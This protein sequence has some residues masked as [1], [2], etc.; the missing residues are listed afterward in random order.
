[1]KSSVALQWYES[2]WKRWGAYGGGFLVSFVIAAGWHQWPR[3][4]VWLFSQRHLLG[5]AEATTGGAGVEGIMVQLVTLILALC[6]L[7]LAGII[8]FHGLRIAA[9]HNFQGV[10]ELM[11]ALAV[12]GGLI[13][14]AKPLAAQVTGQAS[15]AVLQVLTSAA[16]LNEVVGDLVGMV[17]LPAMVALVP[18]FTWYRTRFHG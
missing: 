6:G 1:M 5:L 9:S 17:L 13:F 15:G 7:G 18:A 3:L 8:G 11:V 16:P 14:G 12:G 2:R 4:F 10:A